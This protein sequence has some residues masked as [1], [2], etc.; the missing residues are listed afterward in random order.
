MLGIWTICGPL[1]ICY[2]IGHDV[3]FLIKLL[4]N[5]MD[6]DDDFKEK[7]E[8]DFRHDKIVIF[9]EVLEIMRTVAFL[10]R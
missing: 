2:H 1:V 8:I 6:E 5:Y 10:Y 7:E 9:N 4:C 3:F